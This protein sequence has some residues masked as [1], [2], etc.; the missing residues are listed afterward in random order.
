MTYVDSKLRL[1]LRI[2]SDF[3]FKVNKALRLAL[4]TSLSTFPVIQLQIS[5]NDQRCAFSSRS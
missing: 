3:E 2:A 1:K 5:N 4:E